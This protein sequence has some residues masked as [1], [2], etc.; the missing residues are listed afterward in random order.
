MLFRTGLLDVA[1]VGAVLVFGLVVAVAA[2]VVPVRDVL[3]IQPMRVLRE[4]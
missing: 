4:E 2:S 3:A 1:V